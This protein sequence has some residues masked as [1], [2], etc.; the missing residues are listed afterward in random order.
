[1]FDTKRFGAYMCSMRKRADM[2]QSG[3]AEKL[4]VTRQSVS[5]Y[6]CGDSFPDIS[7][8]ITIADIFHVTLDELILSGAPTQR[9][10][11]V[12]KSAANNQEFPKELHQE[13]IRDFI[14][15]APLLKPSILKKLVA[16][17]SNEGI[18]ISSVI[19]LAEYLQDETVIELL[20]T[21]TFD[22]LSDELLERLI[23]FLD[24]KA[25]IVIF[26]K[27]LDGQLD[28]K[29]IRVMLPYS[30]YIYNQVEVAV[31]CGVLDAKAL[32]ILRESDRENIKNKNEW[33]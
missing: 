30:E 17:L 12:L 19:S 6:E 23:P 20:E 33:V 13:S 15:I 28:Y 2:T 26:Q 22:Q 9:E 7:I 10:A 14:N 8:L 4:N 1:M 18:D 31:M 16:V 21:V 24:A 32:D 3:L 11:M 5:N 29:L 25:Q 27:I